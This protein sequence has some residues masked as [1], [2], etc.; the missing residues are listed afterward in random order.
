MNNN[1]NK[2]GIS[3]NL[4]NILPPNKN[5]K[6]LLHVCCGP[7]ALE[8][9]RLL[10]QAGW[11]ITIIYTNDNI[12]PESEY[13]KRF[14]ELKNWANDNNITLIRDNFNQHDWLEKMKDFPFAEQKSKTRENRCAACYK[15]RLDKSAQYAIKNNILYLAS[16]LAVSPW[17]YNDSLSN[18]L[19]EIANHYNLKPVFMDFRPY[20][21]Q[22]TK[23]SIELDMY[24]QKYCGCRASFNESKAQFEQ[25]KK[26]KYLEQLKAIEKSSQDHQH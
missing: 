14:L 1:K 13:N 4:E 21:K 16:S 3:Q 11:D 2:L 7:C 17:Q 18:V 22:A 23:K 20:Y 24:R 12:W 15:Y 9:Y 8:P 5:T 10:K 6:L 19:K 25:S 26:W